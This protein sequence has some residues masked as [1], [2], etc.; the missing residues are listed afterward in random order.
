MNTFGVFQAYYETSLLESSSASEISWIGTVQAFILVAFSLVAGPIFDRGYFRTLIIT[1]TF[2]ATF[3]TMMTSLATDYWQV[4][5][6]QGVCVGL[7]AGCLFLPSVALVATYFTTKRALAIGVVAA[8]GSIGSVIYP[9]VFHRLQPRIGFPWA[10]R[11][12]GFIILGTLMISIMVM[13]TRLPPKTM[14]NILD[15]SAFRNASFSLFSIG[16]FLSFAGLYVPIFYLII[17]AQKHTHV[18]SDLSFYMLAVLNGASV[19]GRVIPGLLA[20]RFGALELTIACTVAASVFS[21]IAIAVDAL[22]GVIV[23]AIFY[24]FVSGAVVS[25]PS[26]VVAVLAPD[27]RVVGTWMG[28]SFCFAATGILVGNPI[29][30]TIINISENRFADGFIFSGTLVMAAGVLFAAAKGVMIVD[31]RQ[32]ASKTAVD[33]VRA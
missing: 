11:V 32:Q 24:G 22:G 21:Y 30:G 3:G 1:G 31:K 25:L 28:M 26:A 8:G 10:T 17:W 20:D 14:R 23:F 6:A 12:I 18:T 15:L 2:L 16:L 5:L 33:A 13:R 29:A 7:G 27:I 19:F 4:F 9:I